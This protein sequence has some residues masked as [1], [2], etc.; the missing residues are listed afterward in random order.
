MI[1][2]FAW[3]YSLLMADIFLIGQIPI[4]GGINLLQITIILMLF[5]C[6]S[7]EKKIFVDKWMMWY[8]CFV[9]FY[10]ISSVFTG[11]ETGFFR[12]LRSQLI[13]CYT[14]YFSTYV[15]LKHN[16][17]WSHIIYPLVIIGIL[18]SYVTILQANGY[19]IHNPLLNYFAKDTEQED[20]LSLN[21]NL[22]GLSI[23][24]LYVNPVFNGHYLLVFCV[25]SLFLLFNTP[26]RVQCLGIILSTFILAG[27]F[28]CQQRG[29]FFI[30]LAIWIYIIYRYMSS[31]LKNRFIAIIL[32]SVISIYAISHLI[33]FLE[34]SDSRLINMSD[35]GRK[36]LLKES[37]NYYMQHPLMGGYAACVHSLGH[38][39][40]NL[41]I[42]A[43]LAGG[44]FGGI[45]LVCYII[46]L[47]I[48]AIKQIRLSDLLALVSLLFL[49]L[50]VDS[51]VHNTG[52]VE[53]EPATFFALALLVYA[54]KYNRR[55]L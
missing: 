18:D 23:S 53:G 21:Q 40:H 11:Y 35:P 41:F 9:L 37:F 16:I 54:K 52:F 38:P 33:G 8:G 30:S 49:G 34:S 46:K 55:L 48:M 6:C 10:F 32:F 36:I 51:F 29:A 50:L 5:V 43:F 4:F 14:L 25:C 19:P 47:S 24:G 26:K 15:L 13:L 22:L 20:V 31:K 27:L 1:N 45:I 12:F 44:L 39:S 3:L 17:S 2:V 42:S 7:I 28:F